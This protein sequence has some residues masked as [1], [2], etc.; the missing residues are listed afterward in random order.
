MKSYNSGWWYRT[1]GTTWKLYSATWT[2]LRFNAYKHIY[3]CLV[4]VHTHTHTHTHAHTHTH[5]HTTHTHNTHR[6]TLSIVYSLLVMFTYCSVWYV[7][8]QLY[9]Y[10]Y[11]QDFPQESVIFTNI[12]KKWTAFMCKAFET[13]GVIQVY[14][15]TTVYTNIQ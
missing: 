9:Y 4:H 6:G 10:L 13:Q 2:L 7:V 12:D 14:G 5:T 3:A 1:C 8:I 11:T 15:H